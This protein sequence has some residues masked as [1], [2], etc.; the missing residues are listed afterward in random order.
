MIVTIHQPLY[1][2]W[3]GYFQKMASADV[4][5]VLDA[6]S[7][8]RGDYVNR[9]RIMGTSGSQFLTVPIKS[10]KLGTLINQISIGGDEW[11]A[12][13]LNSIQK[14]YIRTPFF[15][16]Y[17]P[18]ITEIIQNHHE[19]SILNL[20]LNLINMFMKRLGITTKMILQSEIEIFTNGSNLIH[21][22][23]TYLRADTYISGPQGIQYLNLPSFQKSAIDVLFQEYAHP[24]YNQNSS[25]F[26]SNLSL[27]DLLFRYGSESLDI[28]LT[29]D[30]RMLSVDE[31]RGFNA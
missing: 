24:I 9:N 19:S 4:M 22:I 5:V 30:S 7:F 15:K 28:L 18:E 31:K 14:S 12:L 6:V 11:K 13:H 26:V 21:D 1:M 16:D 17:F 10:F 25:E 20:D 29:R 3:L 27:L 23:C 8:S 2:P